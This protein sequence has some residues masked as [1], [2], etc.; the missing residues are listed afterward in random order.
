METHK[1]TSYTALLLGAALLATSCV[2]DDLYDTP[3]PTTGAVKIT[4]DWSGCSSESLLPAEYTLR[5]GETDGQQVTGATNVYHQLFTPGQY[6]LL[7]YNSP[8]GMTVG[9]Y[10]ATLRTLADNTA[11]PFPGYLFSTSQTLDIQKDDTLR[12][13]VEMRQR[14]RQLTLVLKL[15]AGDENRF[16]R[17]T[18]TLSGIA[19]SVDLRTGVLSSAGN[20]SIV[21]FFELSTDAPDH[22]PRLTATVRLL[23][24]ISAA[25]QNLAITVTMNDGTS[26]LIDSDLT[27]LLKDFSRSVEPLALDADFELPVEIGAS[28]SINDWVPGL[29]EGQG[30]VDA[31]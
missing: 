30:E 25:S 24:I 3:H 11:E 21:P 17:V 9:Q 27:A 1:I 15:K 5:I 4:T 12:A 31:N 14:V 16:E 7:A 22:L 23:G 13:S 26:H 20:A 19:T 18:A 29:G 10:T 28:G 2:K 6:D 8:D